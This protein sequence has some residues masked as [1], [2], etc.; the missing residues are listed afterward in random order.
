MGGGRSRVEF[1]GGSGWGAAVGGWFVAGWREA[2]LTRS[3][4]G[5]EAAVDHIPIHQGPPGLDV[6]RAAVLILEVVGVL[7]NVE[8]EQRRAPLDAGEIHQGVVL[9]GG[10]GDRE[11][12]IGAA[13]QP[14]PAGAEPPRRRL[15]EGGLHR[16]QGAEA[17]VDGLSQLGGGFTPLARGRHRGPELRVIPVAAAVVAHRHRESGD[18]ALQRVEAEAGQGG[19][20][21]DLGVEIGD[22]GAVMAIV[23]DRHRGGIDGGLQG[24]GGVGQGR[25][26]E[27]GPGGEGWGQHQQQGGEAGQ[28]GFGEGTRGHGWGGSGARGGLS[29]ADGWSG[30]VSRR[31]RG[32]ADCGSALRGECQSCLFSVFHEHP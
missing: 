32:T 29:L 22:V 26:G 28:E 21:G 14:G 31:P 25:Q 16:L 30:G 2:A 15:V 20:G 7:P 1:G 13:D 12:S 27:V 17:G 9:V 23:V 24:V 6:V 11:P 10:A 8:A 3:A 18:L 5:G 4:L 19:M